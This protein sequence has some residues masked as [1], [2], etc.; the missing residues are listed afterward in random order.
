MK[1]NPLRASL[2]RAMRVRDYFEILGV[3]G[4]FR[5]R[6]SLKKNL[7]DARVQGIK[8][9]IRSG[10]NDLGVAWNCLVNKEFD[11]LR[12]VLEPD[13]DGWIVDAGAHIGMSAIAISK[14]FPNAKVAAIEPHLGNFA[15]LERNV[16]EHENILPIR[17]A[18]V[19]GNTAPRK[20]V[21]RGTGEWGFTV[22][23]SPADKPD[24]K[25]LENVPAF[26]LLDIIPGLE[27]IGAIKLDIEGGEVELFQLD[28]ESM[29]QIKIWIVELH[30]RIVSGATE[31]FL[32]AS[33][34]RE[35]RKLDGEKYLSIQQE[36]PAGH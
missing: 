36:E 30:D 3:S 24:P 14:L 8:I 22:V 21:D 7:V 18:L 2:Q 12:S 23:E 6:Y 32:A 4:F 5:Y 34:G 11:E 17:G 16:A 26:R 15:L 31:A 20:L 29:K 13:Y 9:L 19:G 10:T 1:K 25:F 28:L 33:A 27:S 35:V